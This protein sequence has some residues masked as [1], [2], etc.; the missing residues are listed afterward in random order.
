LHPSFRSGFNAVNE[1]GRAPHQFAAFALV[2]LLIPLR[3]QGACA[4][5]TKMNGVSPVTLS[6]KLG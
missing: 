1:C 2:P 5:L 6:V 4:A 3:Y